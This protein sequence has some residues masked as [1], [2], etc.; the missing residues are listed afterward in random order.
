MNTKDRKILIGSIILV[1]TLILVVI[2]TTYAYFNMQVINNSKTTN[3]EITTGEQ[4]KITL[5]SSLTNYH[6]HL[7]VSDM[8]LDKVGS[9]YYGTTDTG[10]DYEI[11]GTLGTKELGNITINGEL[12]D[13]YICSATININ[14]SGNMSTVLEEGDLILV[15]KQGIT[16]TSYD[17]SKVIDNP[18]FKFNI[19]NSNIEPIKAYLK[20]TNQ[21]TDQSNIAGKELTISININDFKCEVNTSKSILELLREKDVNNKLSKEMKGNLYRYSGTITEEPNNYIC[22]DSSNCDN[23]SNNLYRII[24]ITKDDNLKVIKNTSLSKKFQWHNSRSEDT[25]WDNSTLFKAL[26]SNEFLNNP[27]YITNELKRKILNIEWNIGDTNITNIDNI[28]IQEKE[29]QSIPA[30]IGLMNISDYYFAV[31]EDGNINCWVGASVL[32]KEC[33]NT[34]L[35]ISNNGNTLDNSNDEWIINRYG[36]FNN[37]YESNRICS[38]GTI[39]QGCTGFLTNEFVI[40]PVFY[41]TSEITLTGE[42]TKESPFIIQTS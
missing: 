25:P 14:K 22:L 32:P 2:G 33:K 6:L 39:D 35:H 3:M 7:K 16:A 5:S 38:G 13:K 40:R 8:T 9:S 21:E 10:K 36:F 12:I 17:L 26:N 20:F 42:G 37:G 28:L 27:E 18:T 19:S 11:N 30:K 31:S 29:K 4:N 1:I 24:G 41:L 34:W 23:N 15:I